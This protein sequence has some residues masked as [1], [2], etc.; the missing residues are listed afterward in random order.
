[1]GRVKKYD[2]PEE[3]KQAQ[4]DQIKKSN[5][6]YQEERKLF[7][8]HA[9]NEQLELVKLLN[10]HKVE[11]KDFLADTLEAVKEYI[12]DD[13]DVKKE[14]EDTT[15]DTVQ[16]EG[17]E[18]LENGELVLKDKVPSHVEEINVSEEEVA[19]E[20]TASDKPKAKSASGRPRPKAKAQAKAETA[21]DKPKR[22]YVRKSIV[23][24]VKTVIDAIDADID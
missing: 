22:K 1:M 23:C 3:A 2:N 15:A 8:Q 9:H 24:P 6:K 12:G 21:S 16:D 14:E 17:V 7:R 10:K 20:K 4:K 11:D 18:K 13:V 19:E 5:Q